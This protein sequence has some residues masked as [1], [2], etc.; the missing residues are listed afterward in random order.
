MS[1]NISIKLNLRQLKS[2]VMN[3]NG[4]NGTIKC[5][6]L[7]IA[8]NSLYE[9]EKGIYLDLQAWEIKE[10]R[11]DRKDTHIIK[12]SYLKEVFD[13]LTDTQKQSIPI[14]G[15]A[16]LW[17]GFSEPEPN[18]FPVELPTY[19]SP[20]KNSGL[21]PSEMANSNPKTEPDPDDDLPF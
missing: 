10:K 17:G 18:D 16:I 5:L 3:L 14:I 19:S 6:V 2:H 11:A 13:Q 9:G 20:V 12:Q 8:E 21:P 4:K 15:N 1:Q 7:P